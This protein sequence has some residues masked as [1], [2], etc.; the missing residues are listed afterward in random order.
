MKASSVFR[1][2]ALILVMV[3]VA[4]AASAN[5]KKVTFFEPT[6]VGNVTLEPGEYT[7]TWSGNGPDV[8]VSFSQGKA[9]RV[10]VP[11]T[12]EAV[13]NHYSLTSVSVR[14]ENSG[15]HEL[16]A[17]GMKDSTLNFVPADIAAGQ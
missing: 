15:E 14:T 10:T 1:L 5:K 11:A 7:V 12:V 6:I 3:T 9:T 16:I 17:I 2:A 13:Q 8:Q 4:T